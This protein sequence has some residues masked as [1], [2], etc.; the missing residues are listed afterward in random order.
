MKRFSLYSLAALLLMA[1]AAQRSTAQFIGFTSPQTTS[2]T[3][4]SNVNCQTTKQF[5]P[6]Q[7]L[8]QTQ[9]LAT[10]KLSTS[11]VNFSMQFFGVDQNGNSFPI[12]DVATVTPNPFISNGVLQA[13]GYFPVVELVITC[14]PNTATFTLDYAGSSSSPIFSAGGYAFAQ[15][16]KPIFTNGDQTLS[17]ASIPISSP[18]LNASGT[19]IFTYNSSAPTGTPGLLS[20]QCGTVQSNVVFPGGVANWT[21]PLIQNTGAQVFPVPAFPC[22]QPALSY[23]PLGTSTPGSTFSLEYI[24][25][26]L[27]API[28]ADPCASP[29]LP[30][31]SVP[32]NITSATTTSLVA[33]AANTSIYVCGFNLI[34]AGGSFQL[35]YG[36]GAACGT[37][38]TVLTGAYPAGTI[39]YG[40][41]GMEILAPTPA[42]YRLCAVS[43]TGLTN[44]QGVLTFMQQ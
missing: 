19:L 16:D 18:T 43:G 32:I 30:K 25:N 6:V 9:H 36:T 41:A 34:T 28:A 22:P 37:G 12:S 1:A 17:S 14:F 2:Q 4:A 40:G 39:H 15:Y 23:V 24:F 29:G 7:N 44:A 20:L 11:V 26:P 8:G 42:A 27:G 33:P 3:L 38:T 35:E 31:S 21:F 5:F 10:A 13:V